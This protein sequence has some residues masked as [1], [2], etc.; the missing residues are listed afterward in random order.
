MKHPIIFVAIFAS[1]LACQSEV[2]RQLDLA[3]SL[4]EEHPDSSL[5]IVSQ[6]NTDHPK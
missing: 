6:I 2:Q 3:D 5:A 4:L 1:L